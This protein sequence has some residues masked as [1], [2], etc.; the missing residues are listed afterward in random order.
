MKKYCKCPHCSCDNEFDDVPSDNSFTKKFAKNSTRA[1]LVTL[2]G[3]PT[4][5]IGSVLLGGYFY[6]GALI[7][8]FNGKQVKCSN[9][10]K[11]FKPG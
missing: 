7:K 6:G 11:S 3:I 5:G 10:G 2:A 1:V 4:A 8:F 9:C